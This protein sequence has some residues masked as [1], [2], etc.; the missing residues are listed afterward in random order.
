M[1]VSPC[2][3]FAL[4][5]R[6]AVQFRAT[7]IATVAEP[8]SLKKLPAEPVRSID[9]A[10]V[11]MQEISGMVPPTDGLAC[12]NRMYLIVTGA[13]R[14]QVAVG[15]FADPEFMA[16][17]DV[18]FVNRYLAA[19]SAYQATP[20]SAPRAWKVL[21]DNSASAGVAPIQF[22]LA[23]MNAHIN[24]D[25]AAAVAQTCDQLKTGPDQ[26]AHHADFEKVNRILA[27]LDPQIR[28]S[29]EQGVFLDLDREFAGLENLVGDFSITAAR[30]SAW[31]NAQV[32]WKLGE[33]PMLARSY[34]SALDRGVAFASRA[35]LVELPRT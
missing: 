19:I 27:A 22:A 32:L 6:S 1:R 33:E 24:F 15:F 12:F 26:G 20:G 2:L 11:R 14:K 17:L 4:V 23:G 7:I 28:Q 29:F 5:V 31:V 9:E 35:L 8:A 18:N 34:L 25:L 10:T 16:S 3:S 13:V 21:L 30:E